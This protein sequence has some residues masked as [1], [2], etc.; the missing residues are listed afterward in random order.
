MLYLVIFLTHK[1]PNILFKLVDILL[2]A[3]RITILEKVYSGE[4]INN[5]HKSKYPHR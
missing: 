4:K 3:H 1:A 2:N 5:G